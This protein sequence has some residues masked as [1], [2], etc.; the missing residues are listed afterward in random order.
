MRSVLNGGG[1][2]LGHLSLLGALLEIASFARQRARQQTI[3]R[4]D[5]VQRI[6][7]GA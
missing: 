4:E 5:A 2:G 6:A 1:D 3:R 7:T